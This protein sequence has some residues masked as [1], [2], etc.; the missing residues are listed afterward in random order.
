MDFRQLNTFLLVAELGS[1]SKAAERLR[2]AQPA[3]SR[4]IRLLEDDLH[5]T[6]FHRHGRG[7]ALTEAG[8]LLSRKAQSIMRQLDDTRAELAGGDAMVSGRVCLGVPPTVGD[9]LAARLVE[10]FHARHP[11]VMLRVLP[12]FSGY[13]VD[14]LHRGEVDLAIM[15][16]IDRGPDIGLSPL[17]EEQ[18][19]L[20]GPGSAGLRR[21]KPVPF[22]YLAERKLVLPSPRHGLRVLIDDA[23]KRLDM[24]LSVPLEADALQTLKD[25]VIRDQGYTVLPRGA[26]LRE[27]DAGQLCAAP[28]SPPRLLRR[29]VLAQA[30]GRPMSNA[31]RL[32]AAMLREEIVA[33]CE[34]GI[35]DGRLLA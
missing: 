20:V 25:L 11:A 29:L 26:V 32:F 7:M 12:A 16:G 5:A 2:I 8:E 13:L 31:A 33:M 30:L 6:L 9:V 3:L 4:Q 14:F 23:A 21:D 24:R 35:L 19:Y 34:N 1:L 22:T 27:I 10:K 28:V 15:Y 17:I 18:L